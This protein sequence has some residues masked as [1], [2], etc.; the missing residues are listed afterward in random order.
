V[1]NGWTGVNICEN[2]HAYLS[3]CD[4][5]PHQKTF[6]Q[7]EGQEFVVGGANSSG[8]QGLQGCAY[9]DDKAGVFRG[10]L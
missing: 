8:W 10:I 2:T 6:G 3:N 5:P 9:I 1:E 7:D 4:G